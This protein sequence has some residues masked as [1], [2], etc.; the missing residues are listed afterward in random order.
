[1][2]DITPTGH[3]NDA[4]ANLDA[5][6]NQHANGDRGALTDALFNI[7]RTKQLLAVIEDCT[8]Q[9]LRRQRATWQEIAD[10]LG[11]TRSAAQQRFRHIEA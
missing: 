4:I 9:D 3:I 10:V 5:V 8:V 7:E 1:M 6:R 2:I 11:V